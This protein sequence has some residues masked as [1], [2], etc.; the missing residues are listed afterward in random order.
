M[1]NPRKFRFLRSASQGPHPR[2]NGAACSDGYTCHP[3]GGAVEARRP[4]D[5]RATKVERLEPDD[6]CS[7]LT[8]TA[9]NDSAQTAPR[10][11]P[12]SAQT[13]PRQRPEVIDL[14][15]R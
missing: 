14:N 1:E 5:E 6:D 15:S 11:R 2:P 13:A 8:Q 12:D 7:G 10:Q 4:G 9:N 3:M